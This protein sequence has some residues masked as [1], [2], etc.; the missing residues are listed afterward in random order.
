MN[1]LDVIKT[2]KQH[3]VEIDELRAILNE[4]RGVNTKV[5]KTTPLDVEQEQVEKGV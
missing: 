2:I 4:L 1:S 3:T 5:N